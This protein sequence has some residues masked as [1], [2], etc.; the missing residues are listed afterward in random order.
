MLSA[1]EISKEPAAK[2]VGGETTKQNGF[3]SS[4]V[5]TNKVRNDP[6]NFLGEIQIV[7]AHTAITSTSSPPFVDT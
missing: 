2:N 3:L 7:Y 6:D 5:A 1:T 4:L